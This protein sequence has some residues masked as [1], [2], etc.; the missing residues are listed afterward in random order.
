[1]KLVQNSNV[2][3]S[4]TEETEEPQ[5]QEEKT[6]I[7]YMRKLGNWFC[8]FDQN[9]KH[10]NDEVYAHL[11]EVASLRQS[12]R[13]KIILNSLLVVALAIPVFI[14]VYFSVAFKSLGA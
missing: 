3:P 12:R 1:M 11:T 7:F 9:T 4:P 8:G 2:Y 14:Y 6:L 13:D 10:K 5:K